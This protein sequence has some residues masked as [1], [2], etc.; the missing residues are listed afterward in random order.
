MKLENGIISN[1]QLLFIVV[2]FMASMALTVSFCFPLT[3]Q[4]TWVVVLVAYAITLLAVWGYLAIAKRYPGKNLVQINDQVFGIYVGKVISALYVWFFFQL[5]VHYM[6]LFNSF[7]STYIMPETPR[8][9][10]LVIFC[11]VSALAVREGLEVIARCCFLLAVII[12]LTTI[13]ITTLLVGDMEFTNM[14]PLLDIPF[15]SFVQSTHIMVAVPF[16][17]I[18][19]FLMI[20]PYVK[21]QQQLK[22]PVLLGITLCTLQLL[23]VI[24]RDVLVL[25]P[26]MASSVFA[27]FTAARQINLADILTRMDILVAIALLVTVFIKVTIFYYVSVLGTAQILQLRSY[28]PLVIPIGVLAVVIATMLYPSDMEQAYAAEYAWPFNAAVCEFLLP[29]L[30]L[31]VIGIRGLACRA[32]KQEKGEAP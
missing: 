27:S 16:C 19:T 10:F 22:K 5:A 2:A 25:G 28:K 6:Y 8:V 30:T 14:L 24:V 21:Q 9:A 17:D 15:K 12:W 1:A 26:R 32:G 29:L 23:I 13:T 20:F 3:E 31:A 18:V 11:L 4:S 7:W